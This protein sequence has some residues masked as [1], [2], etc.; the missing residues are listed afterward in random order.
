MS[1]IVRFEVLPP[2]MT[3]FQHR[4]VSR[5]CGGKLAGFRRNQLDPT[6]SAMTEF[7]LLHTVSE[8][9]LWLSHRSSLLS[10][11]FI[12]V[13]HLL[14]LLCQIIQERHFKFQKYLMLL[15]VLS[16]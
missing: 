9:E 15:H 2:I 5:A 14:E 8:T 10:S 12:V 4:N 6:C 7:F 13:R 16:G 1:V 11:N 3:V